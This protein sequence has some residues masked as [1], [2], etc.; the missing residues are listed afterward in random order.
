MR[1]VSEPQSAG[2]VGTEVELLVAHLRVDRVVFGPAAAGDTLQL[3]FR[4]MK[5]GSNFILPGLHPDRHADCV[6]RATL[7]LACEHAGGG[8]EV[9]THG[10][11]VVQLDDE[12]QVVGLLWQ[13]E[14]E[15]SD[16]Q[17]HPKVS[18]LRQYLSGY[19]DGRRARL[20]RK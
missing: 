17:A 11:I 13:L 4:A 15:P 12:L 19:V 10:S 9:P 5:P 2:S 14:G 20:E 18:L 8:F 1:C 3:Y 6:G 7:W 16:L